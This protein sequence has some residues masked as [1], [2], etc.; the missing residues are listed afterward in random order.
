[1][2][3]VLVCGACYE[4]VYFFVFWQRVCGVVLHVVCAHVFVRGGYDVF[5][6]AVFLFFYDGACGSS[7]VVD[8]YGAWVLMLQGCGAAC[9]D[10]YCV[11]CVLVVV[12]IAGGVFVA[13]SVQGDGAL[14]G[15]AAQQQDAAEDWKSVV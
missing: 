2:R 1:M 14:M 9:C 7:H 6:Y 3:P 8:G 13:L 4:S 15:G 10:A 12:Q 5:A 11:V